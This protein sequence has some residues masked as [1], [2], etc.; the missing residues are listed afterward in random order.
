MRILKTKPYP[1]FNPWAKKQIERLIAD[2]E[3]TING[4]GYTVTDKNEK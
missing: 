1:R 2:N 4:K 3:K